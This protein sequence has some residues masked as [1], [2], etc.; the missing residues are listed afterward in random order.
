MDIKELDCFRQYLDTD[1]TAK[2]NIY[3]LY[4][5]KMD[6]PNGQKV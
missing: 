3:P 4:L 2:K 5:P 1:K 6:R